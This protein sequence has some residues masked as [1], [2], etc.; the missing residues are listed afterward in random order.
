MPSEFISL[1]EDS[2]LILPI[3]ERMLR[4]VCDDLARWN[5]ERRRDGR[6]PLSVSVN[7]SPRQLDDESIFDSVAEALAST[8]IEP[9]WITFEL[10]ENALMRDT[11]STIATLRA[12][13]QLGVRLAIDDFGTGYS[14]LSYLKRFPVEAL[15]IDRSF[16]DG[17]GQESEDTTIV[18]AVISL[19][20]SLNLYAIAEGL[21]TR[22]QLLELQRL[23]CD[24]AQGFLI[25]EP[26]P[27][28]DLARDPAQSFAIALRA[29]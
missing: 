13:R 2:G 27:A 17:L 9:S 12:L 16:T 8:S 18:G 4:R 21:E 23:G 3:G 24:A 11:V 5:A 29:R 28:C 15:K 1:A 22:D 14:S 6:D 25:S 19:A 26:R 10:T 7:I 20:H